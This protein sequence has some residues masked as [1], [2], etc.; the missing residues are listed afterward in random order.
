[1][2]LKTGVFFS[3]EKR[4]SLVLRTQINHSQRR[5]QVLWLISVYQL[6]LCPGQLP[7][8]EKTHLATL[9]ITPKPLY[10]HTMLRALR[11]LLSGSLA[12]V[13]LSPF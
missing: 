6:P 13:H 10:G 12:A 1:M 11:L 7:S 3:N 9:L 5:Q 2:K 8:L 4:F